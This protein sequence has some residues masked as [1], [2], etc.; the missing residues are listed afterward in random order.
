MDQKVQ[1]ELVTNIRLNL[2]KVLSLICFA[3]DFSLTILIYYIKPHLLSIFHFHNVCLKIT[4]LAVDYLTFFN[5]FV[6]FPFCS[7]RFV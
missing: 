7:G 5:G 2:L 4:F 6:V 1:I 3:V